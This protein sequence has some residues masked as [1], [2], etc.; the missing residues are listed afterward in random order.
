MTA[1]TLSMVAAV[2]LVGANSAFGCTRLVPFAFD[3]LFVADAIVRATAE[4]YMKEPSSNNRTTG[5]PESEIQ[6]RI[7]EVLRGK[8]FPKTIVLNGYLSEKNDYN[9]MPSPY[10]FVRKNGRSGS[11]F[12]NTYRKG[13]Q[14]LLFLRKTDDGYTPNISPLGPS[15]EQLHDDDDSWLLRA[16]VE[17]SNRDK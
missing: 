11:C 6:F 10:T 2:C 16:R 8:D 4:R 1:A 17:V 5:L 9:E 15:N 14:F 12:A 13:G 7:E 3:E